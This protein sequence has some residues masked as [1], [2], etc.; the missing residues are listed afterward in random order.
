MVNENLHS[1]PDFQEANAENTPSDGGGVAGGL[2]SSAHESEASKAA[3][4]NDILSLLQIEVL[5]EYP[6]EK[7][8]IEVYSRSRRKVCEIDNIDRFSH[9]ALVK[10]IGDPALTHVHD[11]RDT[12]QGKI[13]IEAVR[14]AIA[15]KAGLVDL[16][17]NPTLG[18]GIWSIDNSI[19]LVN[20]KTAA[21]YA[22]GVLGQLNNPRV[23]KSILDFSASK[24]WVD[25]TQLNDYLCAAK[26]QAWCLNTLQEVQQIFANWKWK[27]SQDAW[28]TTLL[29]ACTYVQTIWPWRPL[30][31]I[32][33]SSDVGKSTLMKT[34]KNMF[35][36]LGLYS[37]K[38][39]EAGLR[40]A[41][42]NTGC[43]VMVDEFEND[44]NRQKILEYF[45]TTSQGGMIYR[46]T[47]DQKGRQYGLKHIPWVASIETGLVKTADRNRF[48]ILDLDKL[49][50]GVRGNLT[51]PGDST[52]ADYGLKMC[53]IALIHLESAI[54]IFHELKSQQVA[55]VPGRVVE[56]FS[57]PAALKA[58]VE[59][60]DKAGAIQVLVD[61]IGDRSAIARQG[62]GDE[63]DL[64]NAI[65]DSQ[66][67]VGG[68]QP[69]ATVSDVIS[70]GE[71]YT[72]HYEVLEGFGVALTDGRPGPRSPN[73]TGKRYIFLHLEKVKR[74]LLRGTDWANLD[75]AQLLQR[76]DGATHVQRKI[77]SKRPWGI[78]VPIKNWVEARRDEEKSESYLPLLP[79]EE[80]SNTDL[81]E[82]QP[83][84]AIP[85]A[86]NTDE[87]SRPP[88]KMTIDELREG[89]DL[90]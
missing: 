45:R 41:I 16:S 61:L 43:A 62:G 26:D 12:V 71:A 33:G 1:S 80:A 9:C 55:G 30:V 58:A 47:T 76:L 18:Q 50:D 22:N 64:M 32:T 84:K 21:I 3:H 63:I 34:L 31:A 75:C 59:R 20:G 23:G 40:Q 54:A 37:S 27:H 46:G 82:T 11:G 85:V 10:M 29:V 66:F 86:E 19:V 7:G 79:G 39:S 87:S 13:S 72:R 53:A 65:L 15:Y 49:A 4:V 38:P 24:S 73:L 42:A 52:M 2:P 83:A 78:E 51:I 48:I 5:G 88:E 67:S 28:V 70:D 90:N 69:V 81:G 8:K 17:E 77:S 14:L 35:G 74:Y 68:R 56:S 89:L 25:L 6:K 44:A 36:S 60:K 57:V